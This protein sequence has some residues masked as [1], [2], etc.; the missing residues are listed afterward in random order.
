MEAASRSGAATPAPGLSGPALDLLGATLRAVEA[1]DL[2]GLR[3]LIA[4]DGV[5]VDPHYPTPRMTGW[6]AIS[7]GLHWAFGT[8][9]TF[10]FEIVL[11]FE[12]TDG[13]HAAV[14]VDCRHVLRGGH[15]LLFRQVFV[16]DV[17]EGRITRLQAYEPYGP[18]GLV[19]WVLRLARLGRRLRGFVVRRPPATK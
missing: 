4:H 17:R 12:S 16:A 13:R 15:Q 5:F 2:T 11:G 19:G 8:I 18:G 3:E 7:D 10:G 6:P 14:E 9:E 1:K